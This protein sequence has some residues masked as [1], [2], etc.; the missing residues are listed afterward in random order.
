LKAAISPMKLRASRTSIVMAL[1]MLRAATVLA[2]IGRLEEIAAGA[3]DALAVADE[4]VDAAGQAGE[5]TRGFSHGFGRINTDITRG[6]RVVAF[7]RCGVANWQRG[8]WFRMYDTFC[9]HKDRN[10]N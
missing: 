6:H 7:Y 3:V 4:I 1:H 8:A 10:A 9:T 2:A 5:G